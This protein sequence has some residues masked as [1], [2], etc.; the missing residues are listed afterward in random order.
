MKR[1]PFLVAIATVVVLL[2]SPLVAIAETRAFEAGSLEAIASASKGHPVIVHFWGLTCSN[3][4][5][6][7]KDWGAFARAHPEARIVLVN[8]DQRGGDEK[9]MVKALGDAGLGGVT[10]FVLGSGFEEKLRFA[11][12]PGWM[13]ELPY[14]R[15]TKSDGSVTTFSGAADFQ[16]INRWLATQ[17]PIN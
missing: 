13:G 16:E 2:C 15:L 12:D 17:K 1:A 6:E 3:C 10:S 5:A 9:R 4:M 14:T 11:V 7:L 8:W